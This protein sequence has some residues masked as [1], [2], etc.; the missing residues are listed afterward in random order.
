MLLL[1]R[2]WRIFPPF[3]FA[4]L[5]AVMCP[6]PNYYNQTRRQKTVLLTVRKSRQSFYLY[7]LSCLINSCYLNPLFETLFMTLFTGDNNLVTKEYNCND[8]ITFFFI[9]LMPCLFQLVYCIVFGGLSFFFL[10]KQSSHL[11]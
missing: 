6:I 9:L 10:L 4:Y 1:L 8:F 3:N 2:H 7:S 5:L 11:T